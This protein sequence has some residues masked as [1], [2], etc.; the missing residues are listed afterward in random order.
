MLDVLGNIENLVND[1]IITHEAN[2][3]VS[4]D[5]YLSMFEKASPVILTPPTEE[6]STLASLLIQ[7]FIE[8]MDVEN[9]TFKE[10]IQKAIE[11]SNDKGANI[12]RMYNLFVEGWKKYI[13]DIPGEKADVD[14]E[15][16]Y[17]ETFQNAKCIRCR[18]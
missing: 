6:R 11:I 17:N 15:A 5:D 18:L 10:L 2:E 4:E 12:E 8:G 3:E 9:P 7:D 1:N 16:V 14:Y 13:L